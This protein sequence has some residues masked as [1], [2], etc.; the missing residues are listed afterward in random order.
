MGFR[1]IAQD[2]AAVVIRVMRKLKSE[3]EKAVLPRVVVLSSAKIDDNL[4]NDMPHFASVL[5]K[6]ATSN[7]GADLIQ[8]QKMLTA[9][10]DWISSTFVSDE[11]SQNQSTCG[12]GC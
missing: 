1:T 12:G 7:Q 9:E 4:A 2:T 3:S 11:I 8:A 5:V 6:L 10:Q